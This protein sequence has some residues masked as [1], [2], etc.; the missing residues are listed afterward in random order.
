VS[1]T[2]RRSYDVTAEFYDLL[3]AR[4]YLDETERLLDRWLGEPAVGVLDLGAGTGLGTVAIAARCGVAVHAVEPAASMRAVLLSRIAA[5][6]HLL[7]RITLHAAPM[8]RLDLRSVADFAL[9][10]NTMSTLDEPA[11][12][13]GLA[14]VARALVDGGRLVVQRP[15][16]EV[17]LGCTPLPAWQL[18]TDRYGGETEGRLVGRDEIEWRFTYRVVREDAVI[19]EVTETFR[20][21]LV[22][23]SRFDDELRAA[24]FEPEGS[25]EPDIAIAR[26]SAQPRH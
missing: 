8:E 3:H 1:D 24:G 25:D 15:P 26:R 21:F 2:G 14:A 17:S 10:L 16:G 20:G 7:E 23:R 12:R 22:P 4:A 5:Q 19:R 13:R 9:C 18:G 6:P 11:R